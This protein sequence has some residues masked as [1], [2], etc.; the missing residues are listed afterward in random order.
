MNRKGFATSALLY[1][2]LTTFI[3]LIIS[4]ISVI[5][6]NELI[7]KKIKKSALDDVEEL[8]TEI[9]C[10]EV[11]FNEDNTLNIKSYDS[12]CPK[13]VFIP[14]K[15]YGKKVTTIG[16]KAFESC[17]ITNVNI[18]NNITGI[19]ATAFLNNN[20]VRFTIKGKIPAGLYDEAKESVQ[21]QYLVGEYKWGAKN[22][23]VV[24]E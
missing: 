17:G 5:I 4:I 18:D 24:I 7:N 10:F 9:S 20:D 22:S 23:I 21:Q 19:W 8:K 14:K 13:T 1:G 6:N 12:S 3:V 11:D 16:D 2:L 15:I